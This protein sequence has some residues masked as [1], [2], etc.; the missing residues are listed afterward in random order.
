MLACELLIC[1]LKS[2]KG[3]FV[4][5]TYFLKLTGF[6]KLPLQNTRDSQKYCL[7]APDGLNPALLVIDSFVIDSF[8]LKGMFVC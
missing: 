5:V 7:W 3:E 4:R 6:Y 1:C 2:E 8:I